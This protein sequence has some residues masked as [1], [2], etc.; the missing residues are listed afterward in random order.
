[1]ALF[2]AISC[3]QI[4]VQQSHGNNR[5]RKFVTSAVPRCFASIVNK[6]RLQLEGIWPLESRL[7]YSHGILAAKLAGNT[8]GT[9]PDS[10][11]DVFNLNFFTVPMSSRNVQGS[12][13]R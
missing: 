7:F 5:G 13:A 9:T 8:A 10:S 1:M 12:C 6:T 2:L 11:A 4:L 3:P